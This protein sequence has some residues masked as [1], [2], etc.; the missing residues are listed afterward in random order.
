M[1]NLG[2]VGRDKVTGFEGVITGKAYY[3]YGKPNYGI[4]AK[5]RWDMKSISTEWFDVERIEILPT[6]EVSSKDKK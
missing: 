6:N 2:K 1:E 5:A 4:T 3:L